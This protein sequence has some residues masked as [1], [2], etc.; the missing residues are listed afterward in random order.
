MSMGAP[1]AIA[2]GLFAPRP[3]P[4]ILDR[5]RTRPRAWR[6]LS[7]ATRTWTRRGSSWSSFTRCWRTC[8]GSALFGR[9]PGLRG[10]V[11]T[12]FAERA[13]MDIYRAAWRS[14]APVGFVYLALCSRRMYCAHSPL[15]T[16]G[17]MNL[18]IPGTCRRKRGIRNP[19][20]DVRKL[21]WRFRVR[22]GEAV[23]FMDGGFGETA[24]CR[25]GRDLGIS[26]FGVTTMSPAY[27]SR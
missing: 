23:C 24:V 14:S 20:C 25:P 10:G 2:H 21:N 12:L 27:H 11:W 7:C 18:S 3:R 5:T 22:D 1:R 15:H 17:R 4:N 13:S 9:K 16:K 6:V 19:K 26:S 8:G